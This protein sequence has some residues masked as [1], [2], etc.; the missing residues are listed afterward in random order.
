MALGRCALQRLGCDYAERLKASNR[1]RTLSHSE[2][3]RLSAVL[4]PCWRNGGCYNPCNCGLRR[5]EPNSAQITGLLQAWACGDSEALEALMPVVY[6]ELQ[7]IAHRQMRR[8]RV[9]HTLQTTALVNEAYL[10][11]IDVTQVQW[12]DRLH[13]FAIASQLMRRVLVDT[14]RSRAYAKRGAGLCFVSFNEGIVAVPDRSTEF[15]R[16]DD[17]LNELASLDPRKVQVVE[18]RFFGGLSVEEI[19]EV[20]KISPSSVLRDWK[21]ARAWLTQ[22]LRANDADGPD[23]NSAPARS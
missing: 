17:A 20:L 9:G 11:L 18:M 1:E 3:A 2:R 5:V 4:D 22:Q 8:E 13:F 23:G 16:L 7:Q 21:L 15:V 14:A 19:A 6:G 12:R 10:R